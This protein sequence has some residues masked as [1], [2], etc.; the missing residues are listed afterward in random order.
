MPD[1][2][3]ALAQDARDIVDQQRAKADRAILERKEL[4]KRLAEI[5]DIVKAVEPFTK[6]LP[7]LEDIYNRR[8]QYL[9]PRCF[10]EGRGTNEMHAVT[11][12]DPDSFDAFRCGVC[13]HYLTVP[14]RDWGTPS[15]G[16][17]A[18]A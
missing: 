13:D 18:P 15:G 14:L 17:S 9:C 4:E 7:V 5:E 11:S 2:F 3:K 6:R 1:V 16:F 8:T 10:L 12:E